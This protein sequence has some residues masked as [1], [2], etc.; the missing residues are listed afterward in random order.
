MVH[1]VVSIIVVILLAGPLAALARAA[2][3]GGA[4]DSPPTTTIAGISVPAD[5]A[6]AR[7]EHPR[8][9]FTKA[10]LPDI[11]RRIAQQPLKEIY[12][13]LKATVDKELAQGAQRMQ[14]VGAGRMLVPLGLLYHITGDQKYGLACRDLTIA[15]PFG[16]YATEGAYGYDLI[17]DLL[18]PDERRQCEE[19][20]LKEIGRPYPGP[21]VLIQCL[22][23]WG[24]GNQEAVVEKKLT[25]MHKL[26][27][28]RKGHLNDWAADRGGDGNS[29][30]YIGQHEYVGTMGGIPGL[31]GRHRR[32]L[33]RRLHLG[34]NHGP[35]LHL[36]LPARAG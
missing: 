31:A 29:H 11:R 16:V 14:R 36:P 30:G 22:A 25:E 7:R 9:L 15:A 6:L 21:S 35:I 8:L 12:D 28:Q 32:R 23:M 33:V 2:G 13:I 10:D 3:A 26:C 18:T 27:L 1:R 17:Y 19:K 24:G 34:Q 20:I 4:A 5:C